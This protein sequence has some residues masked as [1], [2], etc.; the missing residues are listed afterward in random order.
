MSKL[1]PLLL[2]AAGAV[3]GIAAVHALSPSPAQAQP[4]ASP[5]SSSA[6][7]RLAGPGGLARFRDCT[8]DLHTRA[9][10]NRLQSDGKSSYANGV[11]RID[12]VITS[13][14]GRVS[15]VDENGV[16]ITTEGQRT[17][18]HIDHIGVIEDRTR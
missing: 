17:W 12:S 13:V 18:I 7:A 15:E 8:V 2:V 6:P 10:P 16:L 11:R 1:H 14:K 5:P 9:T 3:L 4:A